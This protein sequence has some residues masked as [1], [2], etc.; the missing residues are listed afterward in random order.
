MRNGKGVEKIIEFEKFKGVMVC[1]LWSS[2]GFQFS[3]TQREINH[4][5]GRKKGSTVL[6]VLILGIFKEGQ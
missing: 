5:F 3:F 6:T 2:S 1:W 4:T